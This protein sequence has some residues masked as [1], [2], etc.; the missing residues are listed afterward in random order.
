MRNRID[1]PKTEASRRTIALGQVVAD[2]LFEQRAATAYGSEDDRVFCHPHTGGPLDHKRYANTLR[3]A[4]AKAGITDYVRPFH[5]GR[6][7]SITNAAAAGVGSAALKARSGHGDIGTT[8]RY[9]DLAG[10]LFRDEAA[11]AEARMFGP[12]SPAATG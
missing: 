9:I 4:L 3:A 2:V 8:Q 7:T 12:S 6:H 5:D 10:V 1:T 11:V